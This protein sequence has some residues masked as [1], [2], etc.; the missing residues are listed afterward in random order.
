MMRNRIA[1]LIDRLGVTA[2]RFAE[3]TGI[4]KNTVY[5]LK[6]RPEQFPTAGVFDRI[7]RAYPKVMPNDIV[8]WVDEDE[9]EG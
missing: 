3:E 4:T 9:D 1:E 7:I 2:Y 6:N 5:D 8:E